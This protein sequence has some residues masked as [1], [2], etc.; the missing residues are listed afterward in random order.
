MKLDFQLA[1]LVLLTLEGIKP[2]GRWEKRLERRHI[3]RIEELGLSIRAV[4]RKV[5]TGKTVTE[6][7]FGESEEL[8]DSYCREF[9][10]TPIAKSPASRRKEGAFFGYP[11]CCSAHFIEKPYDRNQLSPEDQKIL[12]HWACPGCEPTEEL[13]PRYR[14]IHRYLERLKKD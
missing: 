11:E 1:Y 9:D 12:F 5:R 7:V 8:L 3:D 13:L 10:H 6:Y 2:L 4:P 14:E